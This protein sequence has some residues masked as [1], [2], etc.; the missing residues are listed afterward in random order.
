MARAARQRF[1]GQ[2]TWEQFAARVIETI[3]RSLR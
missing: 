2:L 1:E 3:G